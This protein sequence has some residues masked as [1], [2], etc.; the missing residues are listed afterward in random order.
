MFSRC[1]I[2]GLFILIRVSTLNAS[3]LNS[4]SQEAILAVND[5]RF[6]HAD[7][8]IQTLEKTFPDH[9][10]PHL[11]RA[12]YYWWKIITENPA[13]D[14]QQR[15]LNSLSNAEN[16]VRQLVKTRQYNYADVF[17]FINLYAL[18]ARLDLLNGDFTR[19]MRH[20]K[21]S[22][23]Y[24]GLSLGREEFHENFYLTSG[25]YNY[26]TEY[27][28]KRYPFLRLYALMY[29]R[30]NMDLGLSQLEIAAKSQNLILQTEARYFLMKIFLEL[31]QDHQKALE[32]AEWLTEKYPGNLIY[33]Y[34]YQ[35][36]L[37]QS[38]QDERANVARK[39]Y[40]ERIESN[41]HLN[42]VQRQYLKGLL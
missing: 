21:N 5:F 29:P 35:G 39:L 20:L 6:H 11:T 10:L 15:Y 42:P 12:N 28:S 38:N 2:I 23:D 3:G 1:L 22:V 31:E 9:Y 7:S 13:S 36:L 14:H 34:H 8:L 33:L 41:T 30:G 16:I 26:M 32:H 19:A 27:G 24:I 40:F 17:H 18:R 25:L 4:L 37:S